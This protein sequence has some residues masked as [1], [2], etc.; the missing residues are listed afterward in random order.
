ML[1]PQVVPMEH[2][3]GTEVLLL[4]ILTAVSEKLAERRF[5]SRTSKRQ[6]SL[7][8]DLPHPSRAACRRRTEFTSVKAVGAARCSGSLSS[9]IWPLR[10]LTMRN[11][12]SRSDQVC[13]VQAVPAEGTLF[14][15]YI[16][17]IPDSE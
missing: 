12:M 7:P 13:P 9:R 16:L 10:E 14:V 4:I 5:F 11:S 15:R 3:M 6:T 17:C 8:T 1:L 2:R